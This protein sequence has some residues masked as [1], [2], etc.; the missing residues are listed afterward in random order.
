MDRAKAVQAVTAIVAPQSAESKEAR[1]LSVRRLSPALKLQV[2]SLLDQMTAA[3]PSQ[4][5][6]P[7]TARMYQHGAEMLAEEYGI[8]RVQTALESFLTRQKFFPHPSE[9]REVLEAMAVR[10]RTEEREKNP[11]IP[12][13]NCD[14]NSP[15]WKRTKDAD[16]DDVMSRCDCWKSWKGIKQPASDRKTVAAG[17]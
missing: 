4:E 17:A 11:Y 1:A 14:H 16:G 10:E 13:P 3:F 6:H 2:G 9:I 5:L 8:N 7:D 12:D 15:G